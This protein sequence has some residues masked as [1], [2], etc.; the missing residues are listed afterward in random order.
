MNCI[1][2]QIW[3]LS[4]DNLYFFKKI[5]LKKCEPLAHEIVDSMFRFPSALLPI[6]QLKKRDEYT[7]QHAV[8]VSAL[9]VAFGRV[10]DLPLDVIKDIANIKAK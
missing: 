9:S 3:D 2:P 4:S 10:L 8:S 6:A 1:I 7:C 5:T